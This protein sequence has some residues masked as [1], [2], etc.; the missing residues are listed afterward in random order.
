VPLD[1]WRVIRG[2]GKSSLCAWPHTFLVQACQHLWLV[3]P[4]DLYS[5]SVGF[6]LS[7]PPGPRPPCDAGSRRVGSRVHDRFRG[8]E[9]TLSRRLRT[10]PLPGTHAAV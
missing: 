3:W 7:R 10:S 5:T 1:R 6:D 4:N 2:R 8:I 9:V